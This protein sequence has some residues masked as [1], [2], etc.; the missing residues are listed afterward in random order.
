MP[1]G[2]AR[3]RQHPILLELARALDTLSQVRRA[4]QSTVWPRSC[5]AG[6]HLNLKAM[7]RPLTCRRRMR[8][9]AKT[10]CCP[11]RREGFVPENPSC[12]ID[13]AKPVRLSIRN[14]RAAVIEMIK[15]AIDGDEAYGCA[16]CF[17]SETQ[18]PK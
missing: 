11:D 10:R 6:R 14:L 15:R 1:Q 16:A 18:M 2:V 7:K 3:C 8:R 4:D 12:V 9:P 17:L 13:P 5:V